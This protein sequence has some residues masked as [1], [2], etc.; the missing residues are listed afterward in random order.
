MMI[1]S[2]IKLVSFKTISQISQNH[3]FNIFQSFH[4]C[5][6]LSV[7]QAATAWYHGVDVGPFVPSTTFNLQLLK[8]HQSGLSNCC[9][10][11]SVISSSESP[12]SWAS[13]Q[14][15]ARLIIAWAAYGGAKR[16]RKRDMSTALLLQNESNHG[17]EVLMAQDL[18]SLLVTAIHVRFRLQAHQL[19]T[20]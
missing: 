10:C 20:S 15:T 3:P 7:H 11:F 12:A 14:R 2:N 5:H 9:C 18:C 6:G 17:C 8:T 1:S 4:I 19:L 16:P 13:S